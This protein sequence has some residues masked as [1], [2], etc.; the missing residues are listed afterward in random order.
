MVVSS[1]RCKEHLIPV[2]SDCLS[3]LSRSCGSWRC[4]AEYLAAYAGCLSGNQLRLDKVCVHMSLCCTP[5]SN[6]TLQINYTS[7]KR[8][9]L[10]KTP[11]HISQQFWNNSQDLCLFSFLKK[12]GKK[13][14]PGVP[15]FSPMDCFY[16]AQV[17]TLFI[18]FSFKNGH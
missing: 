6:K 11:C 9:R 1:Q 5:E 18:I 13:F 15:T 16:T 10:D 17:K 3:T 14:C 4:L 7:I 2:V 8:K 12:R